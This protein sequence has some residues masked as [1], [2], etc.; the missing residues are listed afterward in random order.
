MHIPNW[1]VI[2]FDLKIENTDIESHLEDELVH[3]CVDLEAILLFRIKSL[4]DYLNNVNIVTKQ[5]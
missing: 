1:I 3:I 2:P 4:S 5:P